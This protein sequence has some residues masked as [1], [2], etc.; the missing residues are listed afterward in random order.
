M[1]TLIESGWNL[2]WIPSSDYKANP[3]GGPL[4]LIRM[5]NVTKDVKGNL[6]LAKISPPVSIDPFGDINS[7]FGYYAGGKKY[8]YVYYDAGATNTLKR[9]YGTAATSN[10]YDKDVFTGATTFRCRFLNALDYVFIAAGTKKY[11]DNGIDTFTLGMAAPTSPTLTRN[12]ATSIDF[13]N[14]SGGNFTNWSSIESSAYNDAGATLQFTPNTTTNRGTV[15]TAFGGTFDT[16]NFGAGTGHDLPEDI[17]S[18][19]FQIAD[20]DQ[21]EYVKIELYG[22]VSSGVLN[23]YWKE[24]DFKTNISNSPYAPF[25][26][27]SGVNT[28]VTLRRDGFFHVGVDGSKA[29]DN[30]KSIRITV[31]VLAASAVVVSGFTVYSGIVNGSYEYF[32]QEV[33]DTGSYLEMS[34]PSPIVEINAGITTITVDRSGAA[35]NAQATQIWYYRRTK[36]VGDFLV[37]KKQTGAAGFTPSSFIDSKTEEDAI[38][39]A[40]TNFQNIWEPYRVA[41]P[42]NIQGMIW[43]KD[44]II[45]LTET[46]FI[47]SFKLDPGSYDNRFIYDIAGSSAEKCLFIAKLDVGNFLIATTKDFYRITGDFSTI[48]DGDVTIQNVNIYA[49]G[50]TDPAISSSFV[51]VEGTIMYMSITGIRTLNNAA[52]TLDNGPLD[53][54]FRGEARHGLPAIS[55]LP[56][57]ESIIACTTQGNRVYWSLPHTNGIQGLYVLTLGA[58]PYWR[59]W[60]QQETNVSAVVEYFAPYAMYREDT[61][62][63]IHGGHDGLLNYVRTLETTTGSIAFRVKTQFNYNSNPNTRKDAQTLVLLIDTGATNVSLTVNALLEDGLVDTNTYTVNT[64]VEDIVFIDLKA[65]ITPAIAYQLEYTG[66]SSSFSLSYHLIEYLVKPNL[67]NR[68]SQLAPPVQGKRYNLSSWG[69]VI[70]PLASTVT[71]TVY[72]DGVLVNDTIGAITFSGAGMQTFNWVSKLGTLGKSWEIFLIANGAFEFY[73]FLPPVV[74]EERPSSVRRVVLPYQA[75][76]KAGR[77]TINTWPFRVDLK[78]ATIS[79]VVRRDGTAFS[80]QTFGPT[81]GIA[82]LEWISDTA[83]LAICWEVEITATLPF[84]FYEFM[85][86]YISEVRPT[87]TMRVIMPY[88]GFGT[89]ARKTVAT[90]PFRI[91]VRGSTL[92][93][94]VKADATTYATQNF[95]GGT[96]IEILNW[97]SI[98]GTLAVNWQMEITGTL[99]FEFFEFL[100]PT[101]GETCPVPVER[102]IFPANNFEWGGRKNLASWPFR[103]NPR[104]SDLAVIVRVDG[105]ALTTVN[106]T[107]QPSDDIRTLI[108]EGTALTLG[109]NWEIEI[110]S[111]TSFEFYEFLNPVIAEKCPVPVKHALFQGNNFGTAGRKTIASWPFRL[112]PLGANLTLDVRADGAAL[113]TQ[114]MTGNVADDIRTLIWKHEL[115]TLAI[116]WELEITSTDDFEFYE[117]LDPVISQTCPVPVERV[118]A[119]YNNFGKDTLKKIAS[120]PFIANSL[121]HAITATVLVDGVS[122]PVPSQSNLSSTDIETLEWLNSEDVAGKDWQMELVCEEGMEFYKFMPPDILQVFPPA[123]LLDQIGPIEFNAAGLVYGLRLRLQTESTTFNVR[124]LDA[125]TMVYNETWDSVANKDSVYE[126][127]VPKGIYPTVCRIIIK[128][129]LKFYRFSAEFHIRPTG[130][131]SEGKYILVK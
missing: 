42:D 80:A 87:P 130:K 3:N 79:V 66:T 16:T 39:D 100:N 112:N 107:S 128:S 57:D 31:G 122:F 22:E 64:A 127:T 108:W 68:V 74:A 62:D 58:E 90:W 36:N 4:G 115:G 121:G 15:E 25:N 27:T 28:V 92:S 88:N 18:F 111:S 120:W 65:L 78:G 47:P 33:Q 5:D 49:M 9:N 37:I 89:A 61:G 23:Y 119:P 35:V 123:R 45:Y 6:S 71:A 84:E 43:F 98:L 1:A 60:I 54:L 75:F 126:I 7:I 91:D 12:S 125:D 21:L 96:D 99:P 34:L 85:D 2:G 117:F 101:I 32:V 129:E 86:P 8:R 105:S 106:F 83:V 53:L 73:E 70:D 77:K 11:K 97:I 10:V 104:S 14:L 20:A 59:F 19:N 52:S 46:G 13:G 41:L 67:I 72:C 29:W 110:T 95:S 30:I 51:E 131:E 48:T 109:I 40:A 94:I 69:C 93:V 82:V 113:A 124:I 55:L 44:R 50:I 26:V 102:V 38:I 17:F 81:T 116:N 114:T 76:G 56:N 63:I 103:I 118:I 24:W